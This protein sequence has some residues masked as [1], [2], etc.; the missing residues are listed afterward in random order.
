MIVIF[1]KQQIKAEMLNHIY[2]TG[3]FIMSSFMLESLRYRK[4]SWET[5]LEDASDRVIEETG[6]S[7]EKLKKVLEVL[8]EHRIIN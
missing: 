7:R 8:Y 4:P 6:L 3:G 2:Y 5:Y 1:V